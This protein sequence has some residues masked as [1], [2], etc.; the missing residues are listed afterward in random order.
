MEQSITVEITHFF[1]GAPADVDNMVKPILD[2][3]K[4]FVYADDCQVTDL[5]SR[6]RP[7]SGP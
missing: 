6:R 1:E 3:M 2:A 5:V 7:L 4:G